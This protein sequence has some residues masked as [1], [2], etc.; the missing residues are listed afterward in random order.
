[1][2]T[3][4]SVLALALI[5]IGLGVLAVGSDS[6]LMGAFTVAVVVFLGA[7]LTYS[8]MGLAQ[9][10]NLYFGNLG[11][12]RPKS[13]LTFGKGKD[14]N[15]VVGIRRFPMDRA[16]YELFRPGEGV[17]IESLRWTNYPVAI[18]RGFRK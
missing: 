9:A 4:R 14:A 6:A 16:T 7:R 1:M 18:Y 12:L 8:I 17:I 2:Q 3:V 5:S 10:H 11:P 15:A 13:P